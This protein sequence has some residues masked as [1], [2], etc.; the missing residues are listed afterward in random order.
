MPGMMDTVLN[1]G[2]SD[3][4]WAELVRCINLVFRSWMS[5]RAIA[6][7][8]RHRITGLMGTAVTVQIMF[9]SQISGVLFTTDPN[10]PV[11]GRM[12]VEASHG[13]GEVVVS[14]DVTPDRFII[15]REGLK[16]REATADTL[17]PAQ[18]TELCGLALQI[19]QHFRQP[20]DIEWAWADGQ[21]ALLQSR[22]IRGLEL[23]REAETCRQEEITRLRALAAGRRCVWV[24]HNLGETLS[25]PTPLTWDIIRPFMTGDGGFG[26]M[27]RDLGY[28]PAPEVC[29]QGFLEL[30][31]GRIYADT[32]RT[33]QL[34]WDGL[35]MS[36]DLEALRRDINTL[37]LAPTKF[38]PEQVDTR[39]LIRLPRLAWAM[40]RS[41]RKIETASA[42]AKARFER[43]VLPPYLEYVRMQRARD[44]PSLSTPELLAELNGRRRR[45]LNEFGAESLKP[46]FLGALALGELDRLLGQ[47]LGPVEGPRLAATLT[48]A[49]EGDTT[50]EQDAML[51]GVALGDVPLPE[52]LSRFG[53]RCSGEMEL[54][55]PRWREDL[56]FLENLVKQLRAAK[57]A[58]L[59]ER[60]R[61][62]EERFKSALAALPN[63]LARAGGSALLEEVEARL[64]TARALLPY[65]ESAKH[66][67]MMGY[68][69][70]RQV[71]LELA[72]RWEF[73]R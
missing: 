32:G 68:E 12:V 31:A 52:F 34:F 72:R 7:R 63:T 55:T 10:H 3:D 51:A 20:Q 42:G 11:A 62:N 19:E 33:A 45:V 24:S 23:A 71:L 43:E 18:L 47:M 46:G 66:Y 4:P 65:R 48:T 49:C 25:H 61:E 60:Q 17:T 53:H 16:I 22:P 50:F 35:P 14:G 54:M 5:Q 29:E 28:R 8:T 57:A 30:I 40:W 37:N 2:L 39:L 56:T 58:S 6:Y 21:F 73:G 59:A 15:E 64:Q 41:S 70:I 36:Y 9:P 69:L 44:L 67:L 13:L 38:E 1:V 26:R 27:Y